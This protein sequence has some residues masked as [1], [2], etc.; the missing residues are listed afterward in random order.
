M[1][2]RTWAGRMVELVWMFTALLITS[3]FSGTIAAALT[4]ERLSQLVEG[5]ADLSGITTGSITKSAADGWLRSYGLNFI[6]Y[7]NV[8]EG[9]EAEAAYNARK[10]A[11]RPAVPR[12]MLA[13]ALTSVGVAI[14]AYLGDS[15]IIGSALYGL[16]AAGLH[17]ATFG[18]D[19]MRD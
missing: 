12:K 16:A 5:P 13:T 7:Q 3:T 15:G 19:P 6:P 4:A 17:T 18:I 11:R 2:P 9:L 10:V 1:A 8:Q 14:A